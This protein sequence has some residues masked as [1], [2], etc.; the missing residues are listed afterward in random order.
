MRDRKIGILAV[1]ETDLSPKDVDNIHKIFSKRLRI[2]ATI[3]PACPQAKEV[4]IV[5]NKEKKLTVIAVYAP[6]DTAEN[7]EFLEKL[8]E[9][10]RG[11]SKPDIIL[12]DWN[13]VEDGIDRVPHHQDPSAVTDAMRE[14]KRKHNLQ[15]GWRQTYPDTKGYTFLQS[16]TGS[17]SRID[18]I[19]VTENIL[20]NSSDWT[21]ESLGIHTDHQLIST[22]YSDPKMP[23]IGEG[24]WVQKASLLTDKAVMKRI[25]TIGLE[26]SERIF[27]PVGEKRDGP[28]LQREG[29]KTHKG[30]TEDK[31]KQPTL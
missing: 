27:D 19:L 15:D 6:N 30:R 2:Y 24:Q 10:A 16:A 18:R 11:L 17:Q 5:V 7:V 31:I 20:R 3:D 14:F 22:K 9:K 23:F 25:D 13:M 8:K 4:A 29:D 28:Y 26:Y 21:I 12:G 1:Q